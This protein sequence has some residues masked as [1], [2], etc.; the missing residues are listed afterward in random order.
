MSQLKKLKEE[1]A[2]VATEMRAMYDL[3]EKENR[4]FNAQEDEH[5]KKADADIEALDTRIA[6]AE[7]LEQREA[8]LNQSS[9]LQA[10]GN[11]PNQENRAG[12]Q[13]DPNKVNE[14]A[15]FRSWLRSGMEDLTP[16]Q[17]QW[18]QGRRIDS[19]EVRALAAG[20]NNAG[21]FAVAQDFYN[22][23]EVAMK[24]WGGMLNVSEILRTDTGALLPMPTLNWTS[25]VA[26]IIGENAQSTLD[27]STPFGAVNLGAYTYRTLVLPISYEF[28]QDSAFGENTI[29]DAFGEQLGRGLNAHLTTGTG[30]GQ[31]QGI[32]T[33][34]T[35]GK[36][37]VVGQTLSVIYD[38]LVDL[39]H[40]VDPA[41]RQ[42]AKWMLHDSG[43]KVIKK[44]KD[45][46]GLP[47]FVPAVSGAAYDTILSY[48]Y[49]INQDM[50]VMAANAKSIVFGRLDKY[51]TRIVR[52]VTMLR[53]VER[54]A[55]FLQVGFLGFMRADG[56]LL[57]A[58]TNPVKYYQNSA[59]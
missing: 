22:K 27:A 48:P 14:S 19:K 13:G 46:N 51:K 29:I 28:L 21:G 50:P 31:P 58:G 34:A 45:L 23:L 56:K 54:Y 10:G 38:D 44:L 30:T 36:V 39:E 2:R 11:I 59:T 12:D 55:D 7:K 49:Q 18:M 8:L 3:A 5:W 4:G 41:Y 53:L 43:L 15:T 17:R 26:T 16:E 1:R 24:L 20:A 33:A 37:G 35:S 25:L 40:S 32:V 47:L 6:N 57:D 42:N 9:G 52:D